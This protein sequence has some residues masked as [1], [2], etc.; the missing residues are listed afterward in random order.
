[1][2]RTMSTRVIDR[3]IMVAH[4]RDDPTDEE[5][6]R[7]L[8]LVGSHGVNWTVQLVHTQGGAPTPKQRRC[9]DQLIGARVVPVAV[10]SASL[11]VR[12]RVWVRSWFDWRI[13]AFAETPEGLREAMAFLQI[14]ATRYDVIEMLL[15]VL[16]ADV[17]EV[18]RRG[19]HSS[20]Q[21]KEQRE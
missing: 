11:R 17:H 12:A 14:P 18:P 8:A 3:L 15:R 1:M 7:Y 13:R 19:S 4:G 5:W 9:L 2:R 21:E 10:M 20:P 16:A 6:T